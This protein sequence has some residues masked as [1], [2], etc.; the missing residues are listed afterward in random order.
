MNFDKISRPDSE[1][2]FSWV[3]YSHFIPHLCQLHFVI[4]HISHNASWQQPKNNRINKLFAVKDRHMGIQAKLGDQGVLSTGCDLLRSAE[5]RV[6]YASS[7]RNLL[8]LKCESRITENWLWLITKTPAI[9][10]CESCIGLISSWCHGIYMK[11]RPPPHNRAG[12]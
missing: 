7:W 6:F 9:T 12:Q 5:K 2:F 1:I 4:S 3:E 11:D 10:L 8:A